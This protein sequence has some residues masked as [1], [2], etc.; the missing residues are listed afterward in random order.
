MDINNFLSTT[1]C[2]FRKKE[3]K[4]SVAAGVVNVDII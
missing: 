4:N 1:F 2:S 3:Q